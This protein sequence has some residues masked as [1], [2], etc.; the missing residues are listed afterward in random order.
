M[1]AHLADLVNEAGQHARAEFGSLAEHREALGDLVRRD[2]GIIEEVVDLLAD[3][4]GNV[5]WQRWLDEAL[6]LV[7]ERVAEQG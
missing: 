4:P 3:A 5:A 7:E 2:H 1:G 6:V